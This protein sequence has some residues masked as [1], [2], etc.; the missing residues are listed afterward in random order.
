MIAVIFGIAC[1]LFFLYA[2]IPFQN[3]VGLGWTEEFL[4]VIRGGL[5]VF[6]LLIGLLC[7]IIG[8][9]DAMDRK[10]ARKEALLQKE[11]EKKQNKDS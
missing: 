4:Y 1:I 8:L 9:A 11:F 6:L 7:L 5:P 2:V 10:N 3:G